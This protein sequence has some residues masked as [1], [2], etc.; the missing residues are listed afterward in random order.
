MKEFNYNTICQ[1]I[2][3]Y[4]KPD[5]QMVSDFFLRK[6]LNN[7]EISAIAHNET[8]ENLKYS[9]DDKTLY[10]F[11]GGI[12]AGKSTIAHEFINYL[13]LDLLP[14]ISS[15]SF[16]K[17]YYE[18][19]GFEIGYEKARKLT[20]SML[21]IYCENEISMIWE[22]ILSKEKKREFL[23]LIKRKRYSIVCVYV[24]VAND[25]LTQKR[26]NE[27]VA[28]GYHEVPGDFIIDRHKKSTEALKWLMPICDVFC[29]LENSSDLS[30]A[31][32]SDNDI[33]YVNKTKAND[34]TEYCWRENEVH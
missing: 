24:S 12:A 11:T 32:Y 10:L 22:T 15:D 26:S 21:Y 4:K 30:L 3:E 33:L 1:L 19:M 7:A 34:F 2:K 13:G 9:K 28:C 16:Y 27:R 14:Y 17:A 25:N 31:V 5:F 8:Y 29:V 18:N 20:D 6:S 23:N